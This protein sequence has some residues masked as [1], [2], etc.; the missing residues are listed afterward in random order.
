MDILEKNKNF[1]PFP[2]D[3]PVFLDCPANRL[4]NLFLRTEVKRKYEL[5]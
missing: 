3:D 4:V 5:I 1:L 2:T